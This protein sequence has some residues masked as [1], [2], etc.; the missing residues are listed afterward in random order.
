MS[1]LK[2][3]LQ[4]EL[5]VQALPNDEVIDF[6]ANSDSVS[7]SQGANAMDTLNFKPAEAAVNGTQVPTLALQPSVTRNV[8]TTKFVERHLRSASPE[9]GRT[10]CRLCGCHGNHRWEDDVNYTYLKHVIL[11]FML[12]RETEVYLC[13]N[14]AICLIA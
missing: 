3:T 5:K 12:S 6:T 7:K 10:T 11:K 1:D 8:T 4:R 2:K 14:S 9:P 13:I